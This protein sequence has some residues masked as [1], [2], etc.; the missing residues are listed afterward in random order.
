[1]TK[2]E[3]ILSQMDKYPDIQTF[4][5]L[6]SDIVI[7]CEPHFYIKLDGSTNYLYSWNWNNNYINISGFV[8]VYCNNI[9]TQQFLKYWHALC[10]IYPYIEDDKLLNYCHNNI[11]KVPNLELLSKEYAYM[12]TNRLQIK[13]GI[14]IGLLRPIIFEHVEKFTKWPSHE[15]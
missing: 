11:Y 5:Y 13:L 15:N 4:I 9:K 6:D 7:R 10:T 14:G 12:P 3:F 1:M 2:A 8:Q